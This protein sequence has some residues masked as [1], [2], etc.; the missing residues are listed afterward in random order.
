VHFFGFAK[1]RFCTQSVF[2][3]DDFDFPVISVIDSPFLASESMCVSAAPHHCP[4]PVLADMVFFIRLLQVE[5]NHPPVS[6]D[7]SERA[8]VEPAFECLAGIAPAIF[9]CGGSHF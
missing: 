4:H 6:P 3:E 5:L 2:I 1:K 8:G 7:L 9:H